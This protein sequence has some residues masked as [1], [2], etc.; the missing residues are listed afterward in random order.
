[1]NM[2]KENLQIDNYEIY[3]IISDL[4]SAKSDNSNNSYS[5]I[6]KRIDDIIIPLPIPI[7]IPRG[8]EF[9]RCRIHK[10]NE[11]FFDKISDLSYRTDLE[12]IT[13]FGRANEPFQSMFYCANHPNNAFFET[14]EVIRTDNDK[15]FELVTH[16]IWKTKKDIKV[17][18]IILNEQIR[19]VNKEFDLINNC[20]SQFLNVHNSDDMRNI[21]ILLEFFSKEFTTKAQNKSNDYL[22]SSAFA[23]YIFANYPDIDG[24]LF[25]STIY[26][27]EGLNY[28]FKPSSID[29]KF[30]FYYAKRTNI[31]Q[32]RSS[33]GKWDYADSE[34]YYSEI[35]TGSTNEIKW[36]KEQPNHIFPNGIN[37]PTT[38]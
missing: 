3:F 8:W 37:N 24:F 12:N 6:K 31:K 20:I 13:H 15:E 7:D 16:S 28:V 34:I 35:H 2:E 19:G 38:L 17:A 26:P 27:E 21:K 32:Y 4:I 5:Y 14:S 10:P 33:N 23:N 18:F 29:E 9:A 36:N 30:E 1:M 11:D 25:P 22:I